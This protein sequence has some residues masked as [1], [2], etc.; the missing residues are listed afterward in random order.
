MILMVFYMKIY[1]QNGRN[2]DDNDDDKGG[3]KMMNM[4]DGEKENRRRITAV[5]KSTETDISNQ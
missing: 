5:V 2:S 1:I 3:G 4:K